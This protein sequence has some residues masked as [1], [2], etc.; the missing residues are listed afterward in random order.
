MQRVQK[1]HAM[2]KLRKQALIAKYGAD[3][4]RN[5]EELKALGSRVMCGVD[6]TNLAAS[7]PVARTFDTIIFQ[8][9]SRH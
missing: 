5:M 8:A 9:R 2:L 3:A 6:G 7:F 1:A 4:A